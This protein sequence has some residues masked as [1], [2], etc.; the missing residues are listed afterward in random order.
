MGSGTTFYIEKGYKAVTV[1]LPKE[2]I[3]T[4]RVMSSRI[5]CRKI[6]LYHDIFDDFL[7][8]LPKYDLD[9]YNSYNPSNPS[10]LTLYI[11]K[12]THV[13]LKVFSD[14]KDVTLK[15]LVAIILTHYVNHRSAVETV[16]GFP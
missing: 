14:R 6:E 1:N 7:V 4:L 11:K 2:I 8:N 13:E 3:K 5:G 15:W 9:S 10:D 12:A 16:E